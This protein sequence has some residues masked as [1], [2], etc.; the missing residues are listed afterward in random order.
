MPTRLFMTTELAAAIIP[1][2]ILHGLHTDST[3]HCPLRETFVKD[4]REI[5]LILFTVV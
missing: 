3:Y 4:I 2:M 5:F 1:V